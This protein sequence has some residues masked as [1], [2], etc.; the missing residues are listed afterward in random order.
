MS[1]SSE[2]LFLFTKLVFSH[3]ITY[4]SFRILV[5]TFR[6]LVLSLGILLLASEY[7]SFISETLVFHHHNTSFSLEYL[8]VFTIRILAFTF[9]SLRIFVFNSEILVFY[10]RNT[11]FSTEYVSLLSEYSKYSFFIQ[12]TRLYLYNNCLYFQNIYLFN[13]HNSYLTFEP[14]L[15]LPSSILSYNS[16][17]KVQNCVFNNSKFIFGYYINITNH[18]ERI[19]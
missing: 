18:T 2:Y 4:F 19:K 13:F 6:L 14:H 3:Q 11:R 12:K 1:L 5:L 15:L 9:L 8:L 7:L 16:R 10:Y 17:A